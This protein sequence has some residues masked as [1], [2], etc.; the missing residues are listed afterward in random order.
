MKKAENSFHI[1]IFITISMGRAKLANSFKMILKNR[2][3]ELFKSSF[4]NFLLIFKNYI[5]SHMYT[6]LAQLI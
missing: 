3:K 4:F 6:V 5:V 2:N 1:V